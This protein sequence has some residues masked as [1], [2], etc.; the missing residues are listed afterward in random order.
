C[1]SANNVTRLQSSLYATGCNFALPDSVGVIHQTGSL[2]L[3]SAPADFSAKVESATRRLG[4]Y[5]D[6]FFSTSLL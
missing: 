4:T 6:G 3:R 1:L 5:L 2:S